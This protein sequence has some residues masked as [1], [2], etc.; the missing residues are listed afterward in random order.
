M[1]KSLQLLA[2]PLN[3]PGGQFWDSTKSRTP[4][5]L[6]RR[7]VS[8]GDMDAQQRRSPGQQISPHQQNKHRHSGQVTNAS[9]RYR[10][11][12]VV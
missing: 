1:L 10:D 9:I 8:F 4:A 3:W 2:T 6:L 11:G 7:T 12:W 5:V